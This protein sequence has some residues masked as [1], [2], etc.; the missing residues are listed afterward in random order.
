MKIKN[1]FKLILMNFSFLVTS[2]DLMLVIGYVSVAFLGKDNSVEEMAEAVIEAEAGK[3]IN[4]TSH[5]KR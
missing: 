1:Y 2:V 3:N 5:Y 4:L